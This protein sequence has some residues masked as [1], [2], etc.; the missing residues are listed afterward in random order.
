MIIH[1]NWVIN[2]TLSAVIVATCYVG[3]K[4]LHAVNEK[5]IVRA[6]F[7]NLTHGLV[8]LF[9]C[10]IAFMDNWDKMYMAVICMVISSAIDLDHFIAAKSF[11][12]SVSQCLLLLYFIHK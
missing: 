2:V 1:K 6:I 12:L 9:T 8:G 4:K 3:D 10:A 5:Q 7:D 11:R